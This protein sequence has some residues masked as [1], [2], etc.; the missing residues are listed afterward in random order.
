MSI[1]LFTID[2]SENLGNLIKVFEVLGAVDRAGKLI[3]LLL[4]L[5]ALGGVTR[6]VL[7]R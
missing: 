2:F 6:K 1:L 7:I 4:L 5:A 3:E